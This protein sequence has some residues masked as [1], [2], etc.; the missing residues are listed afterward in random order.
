MALPAAP[1]TVAS[2][3]ALGQSGSDC[4]VL[5]PAE[6]TLLRQV[7]EAAVAHGASDVH[8]RAGAPPLLRVEGRLLPLDLPPLTAD[9]ATALVLE[10]MTQ[11]EDRAEYA[12]DHERDFAVTE[13][14]VGRF[15]VNAYRMRGSDAMVLRHVRESVPSLEALGVPAIARSL[16][17]TPSGI[18][19]VCGPTGSGK[20]TTL[21]AMIDAIN[22]ER[23]CHILTIEDPIEFLHANRRA[24]ISQR[25]LHTDTLEFARALRAGLRQDPDVMVIGEIRDRETL[26]TALQAA[27]TG[28]LVLASMHASSVIE[29]VHRIVDMFPADEHRQIRAT[30][31]ESLRGIICQHLVA[32]ARADGR[33]LTCEIAVSTARIRDAITDAERTD[34]LH[35]IL[36]EGEHYGMRTS[37]Q[38]LVRLVLAGDITLSEAQTVTTRQSDLLVALR[39]AGFRG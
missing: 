13:P 37:E 28:H 18:V 32:G 24:T 33:V 35:E 21:A 16:A 19:L 9:D 17:L 36:A 6:A 38:D 5:A 10:A 22:D 26:R 14:F 3:D 34:Q 25:E 27:Q 15:R 30:L 20:S 31:A 29:V 1:M 7:L 11:E 39:R 23:Y 8:V 12:R 2:H 4:P